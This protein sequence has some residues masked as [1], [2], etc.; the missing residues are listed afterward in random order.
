MPSLSCL[1]ASHGHSLVTCQS[2]STWRAGDGVGDG[3]TVLP[4]LSGC[5]KLSS[6]NSLKTDPY[7]PESRIETGR[8]R[9]PEGPGKEGREDIKWRRIMGE[10]IT[11]C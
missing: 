7:L 10:L 4:P 8:V 11:G 5:R 9:L 2:R 3:R 1:P 6:P